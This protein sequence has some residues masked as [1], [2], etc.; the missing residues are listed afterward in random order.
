MK[1][2]ISNIA[3][4]P[5]ED[6][7]VGRI[8]NERGIS[9]IEVAPTKLWPDLAAADEFAIAAYRKFWEDREIRIVALQSLLFGRPDLTVFGDRDLRRQ[10]LEYLEHAVRIAAGLG[11]RVLVFGSPKNRRAGHLRHEAALDQAAEFFAKL[12]AVAHSAG[13]SIGFEPN[14]D[15]YGCDFVQTAAQ[16]RELVRR[17]SHPGFQLHLDAAIMTMN[18]EDIETEIE[19]SIRR[20]VHFHVSEPGLGVIGEGQVDHARIARSL[21]VQG[22]NGWAS[23]EMRSGWEADNVAVVARVLDFAGYTYNSERRLAG[24]RACGR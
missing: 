16:G 3:W 22:Y 4:E 15:S 7:A 13:V 20:L 1:I 18:G 21:D 9:G 10:T 5:R 8:L 23:I 2:A 19:N 14:P 11:A 6:E 12:S 24:A 17:V